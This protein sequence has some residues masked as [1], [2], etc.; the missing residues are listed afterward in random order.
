MAPG[1][2]FGKLPLLRISEVLTSSVLNCQD[3]DCPGRKHNKKVHAKTQ[4]KRWP[5]QAP[6]VP[7]RRPLRVFSE[8]APLFQDFQDGAE[9]TRPQIIYWNNG[10]LSG[11]DTFLD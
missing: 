1:K 2:H 7:S 4:P 11:I 6:A 8:E 9:N 3:L 10:M 5:P